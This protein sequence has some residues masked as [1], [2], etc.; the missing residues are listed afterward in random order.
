MSRLHKNRISCCP[1]APYPVLAGR[2]VPVLPGGCGPLLDLCRQGTYNVH[3]DSE[4]SVP[5]R[6]PNT[7]L[8]NIVGD[9]PGQWLTLKEA[10]EV[11]GVHFTTL[12]KWADEGEIRVFRTP[13][14][15]RRFSAGDLRRFLEARVG[16]SPAPDSS[17]FVDVAVDRVRAEMQRL[18]Q[19]QIGWAQSLSDS[20]RDLSRLRGRRL[21]ALAI[22]YVLKPGQ[23]AQLLA[24][25][26]ELGRAYGQDAVRNHISLIETGRAVQFFRSQ[27]NHVLHSSDPAHRIDAD[28]RRIEQAVDQ[29]LDEVL[30]AVLGGYE[31]ALGGDPTI[32]PSAA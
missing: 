4:D 20:A 26:R 2:S 6:S 29:F 7:Q 8:P 22:A 23:R 11:L 32:A 15:H 28:D 5:T 9:A 24:E 31:E 19:E 21:F 16:Q 12:R 25:G 3:M 1:G 27:L 30:Y 13:G 10:A 18:S 17:G 14:G